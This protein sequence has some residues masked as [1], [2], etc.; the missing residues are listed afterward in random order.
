MGEYEQLMV[1]PFISIKRL[2]QLRVDQDKEFITR[3]CLKGISKA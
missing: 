3:I 2:Y 1:H